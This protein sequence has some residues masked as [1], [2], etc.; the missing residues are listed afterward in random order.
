MFRCLRILSYLFHPNTYS[1]PKLGSLIRDWISFPRFTVFHFSL[2][3]SPQ[4]YSFPKHSNLIWEWISFP[5]S[6]VFRFSPTYSPQ[7]FQSFAISFVSEF[8]FQVSFSA[9][10]YLFTTTTTPFQSFTIS[11]IS[12][13]R[14]R[15]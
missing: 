7:P 2:T 1:F 10:S 5:C 15:R 12:Q 14:H 6:A 4:C 8:H 9:L 11:F 13:R 3:Y